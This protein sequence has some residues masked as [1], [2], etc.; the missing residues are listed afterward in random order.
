M[1]KINVAITM[2]DPA[3]I[4]PEIIIKSLKSLH[5]LR[6]VHF[7]VVGDKKLFIKKGLKENFRISLVDAACCYG[8]FS[9]G[10]FSKVS[11]ES[12][13]KSLEYAVTLLK[14]GRADCLVTAPISKE[15]VKLA[16][17]SW[18]GHTEYLAESFAVRQV[19][20]VFIADKLKIVLVTRH[21]ALRDAIKQVKKETIVS[22]GRLVF[23]LLRADFKIKNPKIAVCGLNPHAG[24]SGLFGD[25]ER[26]EIKPAIRVLNRL[27]GS[28]F[29]GP[30]A[31][32]TLFGR[33]YKGEFDLVVAMYHDQGLAPFKLAAFDK[34]VNLTAGLPFIRT[35]PVGGTAFDIA[36]KNKADCSSMREA[37]RLA[38]KL[39]K[40]KL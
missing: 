24:E 8:L 25:E 40:K 20:M 37:I 29:S 35:S 38:C 11:G 6:D 26:R 13:F 16:G 14:Q 27:F 21:L 10:K 15:A 36:G 22:C 4:G 9:P 32:D 23:R 3:G 19:E 7:I 12:S 30:Y 39:F 17:F 5:G 31:A 18:P 2:G 1:E 28:H 34:G 33:A